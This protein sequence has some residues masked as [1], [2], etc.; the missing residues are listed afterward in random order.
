L[1]GGELLVVHSEP[2]LLLLELKLLD[3]KLT[4]LLLAQS[5]LP[6]LLE[7]EARARSRNRRRCRQLLTP[8]SGSSLP[9]SHPIG[10]HPRPEVRLNLQLSRLPLLISRSELL[11]RLLLLTLSLVMLL[12]DLSL[13]LSVGRVEGALVVARVVYIVGEGGRVG[14][15]GT[16]K[17]GSVRVGWIRKKVG[18]ERRGRLRSSSERGGLLS[19][20]DKLLLKSLSFLQ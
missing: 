17:L 7:P 10:T 4:L 14:G 20:G 5:V 2:L 11:R 19:L 12:L 1:T 9:T 6:R 13:S 16:R 3:L 8:S 15:V 18:G